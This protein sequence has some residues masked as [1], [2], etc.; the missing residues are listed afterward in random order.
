LVGG[1]ALTVPFAGN[2]YAIQYPSTR[3]C[4][5]SGSATG[6]SIVLPDAILLEIGITLEIYNS[7]SDTINVKDFSGTTIFT[8]GPNT[9]AV[10]VLEDSSTSAGSWISAGS[11]ITA[12]IFAS[13]PSPVILSHNGTMSN[14][15]LIGYTNLANIAVVVGFKAKLLRV[16]QNN[17]KASSD[18]SVDFFFGESD[19]G[20]NN[21]FHRM[22]VVNNSP[23]VSLVAPG[24]SPV[25]NAGDIIGLYYRDE[26][27]NAV[28]LNLGLF[29][30]ATF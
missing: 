4:F 16:T 21:G 23:K 19:G 8:L 13:I 10:I 26:G 7:T 28:D 12:T 30:E 1:T 22:T 15:Q 14:N 29:F 11:Q 2:Q 24:A 27:A 25:F 17:S 3:A 5:I 9:S 6:Q 18:F 20:N